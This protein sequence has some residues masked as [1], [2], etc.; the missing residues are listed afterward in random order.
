MPKQVFKIKEFHG[1]INSDSDPRDLREGQSPTMVDCSIDSVGRLKLMGST[2][3]T[4]GSGNGFTHTPLSTKNKGLF[5]MSSDRQFDG[6][7]ADETLIF[8]YD[9]GGNKVDGKDSEGWDA[10][11]INPGQA[12][13]PLY[14]SADGILRVGDKNLSAKTRWFG[15][16]IDERFDG[17]NADSGSIGWLDTNQEL[18]K[19]SSGKCLMSTPHSASDSNGVNSTNSE[20]I[21]D[22][23]DNSGTDV[24]VHSAV[25]LRAGVQIIDVFPNTTSSMTFGGA[26]GEDNTDLYPLFG[27]NNIKASSNGN[28]L[29]TTINDS[30]DNFSVTEEQSVV[31]GFFVSSAELAKLQEVHITMTSFEWSFTA[32]QLLIKKVVTLAML[33][34]LFIY[35]GQ[36]SAVTEEL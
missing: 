36:C 34:L 23:I 16:V 5:V 14:Y 7:S 27:D 24:A 1:G 12:I 25:N 2:S 28:A 10:D 9:S 6:G 31:F 33:L 17:I 19:P 30:V 11:L 3:E 8:S 29:L 32:D 15:Y 26:A 22:V 21:G 18:A 13:D 20:Y 35:Q 4:D